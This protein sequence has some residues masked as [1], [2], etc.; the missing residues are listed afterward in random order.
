MTVEVQLT[1]LGI[2][3]VAQDPAS[4]ETAAF[5]LLG[6]ARFQVVFGVG[7]CADCSLQRPARREAR[8]DLQV[9]DGLGGLQLLRRFADGAFD[10]QYRG[11]TPLRSAGRV[12]N[13]Y[14][15][16]NNT[17]YRHSPR[18]I[19]CCVS[20][21]SATLPSKRELSNSSTVLWPVLWFLTSMR[22]AL[23]TSSI[24]C[25]SRLASVLSRLPL[26]SQYSMRRAMSICSSTHQ[27]ARVYPSSRA[28]CSLTAVP[29]T[30]LQGAP[31]TSSVPIRRNI[32]SASVTRLS[33]RI[34]SNVRSVPRK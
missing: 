22:E 2:G 15:D 18:S 34:S 3:R 32:Q 14:R 7:A 21:A 16:G 5:A 26:R 8:R 10:A 23:H 25:G 28:T 6:P 12:S 29:S 4:I 33:L 27:R 13:E 19:C 9:C 31:S 17:A 24:N 1:Q 20:S 30:I 11:R